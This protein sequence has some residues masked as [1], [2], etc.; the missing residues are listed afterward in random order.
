MVKI[1]CIFIVFLSSVLNLSAQSYDVDLIP[2]E[3]KSYAK[4]VVRLDERT[5]TISSPSNMVYRIR[6]AT[7]IFN[8]ANEDLAATVVFYNKTKKIKSL[9]LNIYDAKGSLIG[10]VKESDFEDQSCISDYSLFE[11]ARMKRYFP[12]ISNYPITIEETVEIRNN[13]TLAIPDWFPQAEDN[14]SIEKGSFEIL[15]S[16]DYSINFKSFG[17][18]KPQITTQGKVESIK[19][20]LENVKANKQEPYSISADQRLPNLKISPVKFSYDGFDGEYTDWKSYGKWVYDKLLTGRNDLPA[21]TVATIKN[22]VKDCKTQ[23]EA[24]QLIY[25]YAQKKNRYISVQ[26]GIGGFQPMKASEVDAMSYG[27]CKAL[28]NYTASLL[29]AAGIESIYTEVCAG[30]EKVD[31]LKDFASIGQGNHIILCLPFAKDTTWLECTSKDTP[32]G[33]LGSFTQDRR[34]LLI[35]KEGGELVKTPAYNWDK[36]LQERNA[37]FDLEASGK[38]TGS[39]KTTFAGLQYENREGYNELT[40]IKKEEELKSDYGDIPDFNMVSYQLQQ[41]KSAPVWTE[42]L[43]LNTAHFVNKNGKYL[44]FDVNPVN[45]SRAN[46]K[47]VMNRKNELYINVGYTDIDSVRINIPQNYKVETLP[48]GIDKTFEFGSYQFK[49]IVKNGQLLTVRKMIL[50]N[51]T[52]LAEAYDSFLTFYETA[53]KFDK[54][55]CVLVAKE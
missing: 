33:F 46:P 55:R 32:F 8:Q 39:I 12:S 29:S 38:L 3:L 36:N 21:S 17:I 49:T 7:T 47:E 54:S 35:K 6:K 53:K 23:K 19:W 15:K 37:Y 18:A 13:Q 5:I 30:R 11:D 50:K 2:K 44:L 24:A 26:I 28:V 31:Y 4:A 20:T 14:I 45:V 40:P 41:E 27:D 51:G 10:K 52:Y 22:L 1:I 16:P 25:E 34:V 48:M 43:K 42:N 9:G